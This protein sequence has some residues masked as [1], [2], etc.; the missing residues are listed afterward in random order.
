MKYIT[1]LFIILWTLPVLAVENIAQHL[2]NIS[3]TI[4]SVGKYGG[5]ELVQE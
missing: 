4:K 5:V 3:V 2:Q 1:I